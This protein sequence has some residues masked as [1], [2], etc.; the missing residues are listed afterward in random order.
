MINLRWYLQQLSVLGHRR[1]YYLYQVEPHTLLLP[2]PLILLLLLSETIGLTRQE[3]QITEKVNSA[4]I[5]DLSE[6]IKLILLLYLFLLSTS[7]L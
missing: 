7:F 5:I 6:E 3:T 2:L 1:R 4:I